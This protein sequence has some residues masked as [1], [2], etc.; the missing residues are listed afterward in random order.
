MAIGDRTETRLVNPTVITASNTIIG[1][2]PASTVWV[3]KQI[4]ICNTN[5]VD[6]WIKLAIGTTA[7][8]GNCFFF[9]LP[10]AA[11]DTLVFDT[12]LVLV[13]AETIQ[14]ISDR[15]AI[16]ITLTGWAKAV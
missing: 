13:A 9:Q 6:A 15:G 4:I 1:T 5:G 12:A 10:I 16:N 7:T 8:A 14:A 11:Y 2:V 3:T